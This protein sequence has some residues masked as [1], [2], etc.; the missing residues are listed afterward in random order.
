[1]HIHVHKGLD[2]VSA[3]LFNEWTISLPLP[4]R[5][6]PHTCT[7]YS[8]A[9][10]LHVLEFMA[11]KA[12]CTCTCNVLVMMTN[13]FNIMLLSHDRVTGMLLETLV[14]WILFFCLHRNLW[15]GLWFWRWLVRVHPGPG[16]W[17]W[18]DQAEW[19]DCVSRNRTFCRPHNRN[20]YWSLSYM[21]TCHLFI[22]ELPLTL[23]RGTLLEH[24]HSNNLSPKSLQTTILPYMYLN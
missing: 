20:R 19:W 3:Q 6:F 21:C 10:I 11:L 7:V 24:V 18:L 1:M 12:N 9:F 5:N 22:R 14:N 8:Q 17:L 4:N 2:I 23:W 15:M 13:L 16:W